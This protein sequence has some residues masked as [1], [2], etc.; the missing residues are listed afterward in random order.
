MCLALWLVQTNVEDVGED[1]DLHLFLVYT[2]RLHNNT[3]DKAKKDY[4]SQ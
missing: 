1:D 4:L 3:V 2:V